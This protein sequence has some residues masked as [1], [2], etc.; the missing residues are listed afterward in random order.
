[1][2]KQPMNINHLWHCP[3]VVYNRADAQIAS[4]PWSMFLAKGNELI[5]LDWG[6]D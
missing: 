6:S 4:I 3:L 5:N 1:M 2:N